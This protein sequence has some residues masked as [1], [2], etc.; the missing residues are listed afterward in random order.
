MDTISNSMKHLFP[1]LD[2][3]VNN[4]PLIYLDNAATTQKPLE[5][6]DA[7]NDYYKMYNSNIHRGAHYLANYATEKYEEARS[8]ISNFINAYDVKEINFTKGTTES[9][10]LLAYSWGRK[11]VSEGDEILISSVEHH[12]NI[13]P[14][15]I[16]CEEKNAILKIIEI[17]QNK[18]KIVK[19]LH[20]AA[21]TFIQKATIVPSP[22]ANSENIRPT[23]KKKGAP[24]G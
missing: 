9:I 20:K 18:N 22:I 4:H 3:K 2:I 10:N 16:L 19:L 11:Y 12:A 5:V 6:I 15:Q 24:G 1:I 17:D 14:W 8:L 7:M 21:E 13:V 23:N